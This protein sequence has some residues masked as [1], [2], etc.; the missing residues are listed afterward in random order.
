M[1]WSSLK[2]KEYPFGG[3]DN[4]RCNICP[5]REECRSARGVAVRSCGEGT[6]REVKDTI[7]GTCPLEEIMYATFQ[8]MVVNVKREIDEKD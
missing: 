1:R 8:V 4:M 2:K 5:V 7:R 6:R 3:C